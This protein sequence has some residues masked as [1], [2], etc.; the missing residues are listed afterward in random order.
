MKKWMVSLAMISLLAV[1]TLVIYKEALARPQLCDTM[2]YECA[3]C[4]G[5][6]S[7]IWCEPYDMNGNGLIDC[8]FCC[9]NIYLPPPGCQWGHL[10]QFCGQCVL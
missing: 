7:L 10:G 6:W 9:Y 1:S 5:D 3:L 2:E 8:Q 4:D